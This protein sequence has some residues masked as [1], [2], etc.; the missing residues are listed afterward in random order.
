MFHS[1]GPAKAKEFVTWMSF[2]PRHNRGQSVI[3]EEPNRNN[4]PMCDA[5]GK[6]KDDADIIQLFWEYSADEL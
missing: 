1:R 5:L 6:F 3:S 2:A 4:R